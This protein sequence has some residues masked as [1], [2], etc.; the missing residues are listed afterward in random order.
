MND[1]TM[2]S[3]ACPAD[4]MTASDGA[5]TGLPDLRRLEESFTVFNRV[6]A[7]L[8]AAYA[9]LRR[10]AARIDLKLRETNRRLRRKV[11][12]LRSTGSRLAEVL[13]AIPSG[14]VVMDGG[15][16]VVRLNPPAARILGADAREIVG[17]S[18]PALTGP[19]GVPL[20]LAG[21]ASPPRGASV[22]RVLAGLDGGRRRVASTVADLEGGGRIEIL[23]DLTE[24]SFLREQVTRL[25]TLAALGEMAASVAHEIRNPLNGIKGF[26]VLLARAVEAGGAEGD[27]ALSRRYAE[28]IGRGV[29]EVDAIISNLLLFARPE[30]LRVAPVDIPGLV[31]EMAAEVARQDGERRPSVTIRLPEEAVAAVPGD[32]VKLRIILG[33]LLRNALEAAGPSGRV[34][35]EVVAGPESVEVRVG[36][37]G[38]GIAPDVRARLFRPFT[39]TKES[40]TGLGLAIAHKLAALHGGSLRCDN[41]ETGARFVLEMRRA[42]GRRVAVRKRAAGEAS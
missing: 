13:N 27:G 9:R 37:D 40:G 21:T 36:D 5:E 20:L 15:G 3:E 12:Q 42:P 32:R 24:V 29:R 41:V 39:T 2:A 23:N 11:R 22:E 25:D 8:E 30:T 18:A 14:V 33:N 6:T 38:P 34:E 16:V 28:N 26:A 17:R 10:R 35:V 7:D 31:E 1:E 4:L 19:G